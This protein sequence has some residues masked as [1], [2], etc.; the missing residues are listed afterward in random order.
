MLQAA[1]SLATSRYSAHM[2]VHPSIHTFPWF[3]PSP[4]RSHPEPQNHCH[5]T[6][7]VLMWTLSWRL[8]NKSASS[9]LTLEPTPELAGHQTP[10]PHLRGNP[11]LTRQPM[12]QINLWLES[13]ANLLWMSLTEINI[14]TPEWLWA[15]VFQS[16]ATLC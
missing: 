3:H 8:H 16:P 1:G 12:E 14:E 11:R 6:E 9:F 10:S 5:N 13:S 4:S 15:T 2:P 7:Q